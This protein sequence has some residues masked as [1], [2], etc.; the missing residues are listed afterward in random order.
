MIKANMNDVMVD[1]KKLIASEMS[2]LSLT[3][4]E[5]I[6]K[7]RSEMTTKFITLENRMGGHK[8]TMDKITKIEKSISRV[9]EALSEETCE[10]LKCLS[11]VVPRIQ[12]LETKTEGQQ[13][14]SDELAKSLEHTNEDVRL[15]KTDIEALK[16]EIL[17]QRKL[18]YRLINDNR[19]TKAKLSNLQELVNTLD[20]R[21]RKHNLIFEGI[22][23]GKK[24]NTKQVIEELLTEAKIGFDKS[25]IVSAYMLGKKISSKARPILV[26]FSNTAERDSCLSKAIKIKKQ[27]KISS[28]WINKDLSEVTRI[29][30]MEVRKCYNLMKKQKTQVS[31]ERIID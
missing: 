13:E 18:I 26:S 19:K 30:S 28:L 21:Q 3:N 6:S 4:D 17:G 7:L 5:S 11:D 8:D 16:E 15:N 1:M 20:N 29:K 23:E 9:K 2:G 31:I 14:S 12:Q 27:S 25:S 22:D 10:S 24:E